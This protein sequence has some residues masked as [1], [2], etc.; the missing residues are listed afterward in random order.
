MG[1]QS[2][3][4]ARWIGDSGN[5]GNGAIGIVV[6]FQRDAVVV[7]KCFERVFAALITAFSMGNGQLPNLS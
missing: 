5:V 6:V 3:H 1:H 2:E 7:L 4:V